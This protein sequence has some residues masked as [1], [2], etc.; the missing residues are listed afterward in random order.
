MPWERKDSDEEHIVE[1]ASSRQASK[2]VD[3]ELDFGFSDQKPAMYS[4]E[5]RVA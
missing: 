5:E 3:A 4:V 1:D 2:Q